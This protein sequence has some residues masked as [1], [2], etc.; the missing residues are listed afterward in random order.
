MKKVFL[1]LFLLLVTALVWANA[2]FEDVEN[3]ALSTIAAFS[4]IPK[5]PLSG[6]TIT[7]G[8]DDLIP[9]KITYS[10]SDLSYYLG[11]LSTKPKCSSI[12]EN[13]LYAM[14]QR[15]A[16]MQ[17]V[18]SMLSDAGYSKGDAVISGD[19]TLSCIE[20][21]KKDEIVFSTDLSSIDVDADLDLILKKPGKSY[22]IKGTLNIKGD[23]ER[24]LS[25]TSSDLRV[26]DIY[27][28]VSLK[29]RLT[30]AEK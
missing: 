28:R 15:S 4:S 6:V 18:K 1:V 17:K 11:D 25:V 21:P 24:T 3:T 23:S 9:Q 10:G 27:Y 13:A 14:T 2:C 20:K 30:K 22:I 26:N 19:V 8:D 7:G 16:T 29:Y 5:I 12:W